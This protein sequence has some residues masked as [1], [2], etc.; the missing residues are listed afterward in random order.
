M[1]VK[2]M[3]PFWGPENN[4]APNIQGVQ[5]GTLIM[6]TTLIQP[7]GKKKPRSLHFHISLCLGLRV[8]LKP[9]T[10]PNVISL[11]VQV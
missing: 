9:P 1:V 10:A 4:T 3:G 5:K 11:K 7:S 2:I 8:T 6:T